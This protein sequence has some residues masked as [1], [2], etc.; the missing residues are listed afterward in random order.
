VSHS[1]RVIVWLGLV[2]PA[3][4]AQNAAPA[5]EP[6][7]NEIALA[8]EQSRLGVEAAR[9]LRWTEARDAFERSY[10]LYPR[11]LTLLNLAGAQVESGQLVAGVESYRRFL[12]QATSGP[13][14]E[15][16][17]NAQHALEDAEQRIPRV[18]LAATGLAES[19]ELMLDGQVVS[20]AT[21]GAALPVD[22]GSHVLAVLRNRADIAHLSFSVEQ[23][24]TRDVSIDVPPVRV[25][26]PETTTAS[27]SAG[28]ARREDHA[29]Q[30]ATSTTASGTVTVRRPDLTTARDQ[31]L[32]T[33]PEATPRRSVFASPVFWVIIGAVVAGGAAA[34]GYYY[35]YSTSAPA[36]FMGNANPASVTVR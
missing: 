5:H 7:A 26:P 6:T 18:R 28:P 17:A 22:P 3:A 21:L 27:A 13:A 34:G 30:T 4:V 20:H 31:Q 15:Q 16:R 24:A 1:I 33:V 9:Q 12:Q 36:P 29:E 8:R 11:P 35:W 23:R 32:R 14:A 10:R 2:A 19:D 25:E